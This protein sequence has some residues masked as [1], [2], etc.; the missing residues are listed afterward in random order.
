MRRRRAPGAALRRLRRVRARAP[1][2]SRRPRAAAP[3]RTV[4][5]A[6]HLPRRSPSS[7]PTLDPAHAVEPPGRRTGQIAPP[8]IIVTSSK[9]TWTPASWRRSDGCRGVH[10]RRADLARP[11]GHREPRAQRRRRRPRDV[12][13]LHARRQRA[14]PT[15]SG[16]GSPTVSS[17]SG[18]PLAR[19]CPS[20]DRRVPRVS[21]APSDAPEVHIGAYAP[22]AL[23]G[24]RGRQRDLD[25][26]PRPDTPG[27][28][29][30]IRTGGTAPVTL[31]KPIERLLRGTGASVQMTDAIARYGLDP[32]VVQTAVVV[33]T[34]ADAVGI[35]RYTVLGGGRIAPDPAW[36]ASHITTE[37]VPILGTVTC[38][39]LIFPQLRAALEEVTVQRPGR[40][41]PPRRVR[42]LLL[43]ALHRRLHR[44]CPTTPSGWR[45]TSTSRATSA[46][47]SAR[48]TAA[49]WRSS[50]AGA[51]PGAATGATPTRCTSR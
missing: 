19:S 23:A 22:Q 42:R 27:N 4:R 36:A 28:A 29:L 44:R 8:D 11:G 20:D 26:R 12:P 16:T 45:S 35:Y 39:K 1:T 13:Q 51:S 32:D 3:R 46:A 41:D 50:R 21:A 10:R 31:R 43:P 34:I 25:R 49:W 6:A 2:T 38:N 9:T 5:P 18:A 47:P 15:R 40:Q 33:G 37:A 24:R 48:W 30:L 7:G 14:E 17:R